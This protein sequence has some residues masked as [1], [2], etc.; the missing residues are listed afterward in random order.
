MR[1]KKEIRQARQLKGRGGKVEDKLTRKAS[2][3]RK[4]WGETKNEKAIT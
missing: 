4:T 3:S 1:L 2:V